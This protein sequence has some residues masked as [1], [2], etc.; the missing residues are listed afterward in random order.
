[1]AR[2][3]LE[4]SL[5][6]PEGKLSA[7]QLARLQT[8]DND[9]ERA[10]AK[11]RM[12]SSTPETAKPKPKKRA[13]SKP[14]KPAGSTRPPKRPSSVRSAA[15]PE[16][17]VRKLNNV[18]GGRGDGLSEMARRAIDRAPKPK[19]VSAGAS[20]PPTQPGTP[21]SSGG[22]SVSRTSGSSSSPRTSP[23]RPSQP[24]RDRGPQPPKERGTTDT[25]N[26]RNQK[27]KGVSF[28]DWQD[29]NAAERRS[30]GLPTSVAAWRT[31]V[32]N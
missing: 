25:S 28:S 5:G 16:V 29:M 11:K 21:K 3:Q 12:L 8:M 31:A 30:K 20:N 9:R 10:K 27:V 15:A 24:S 1:M 7:S 19:A 14:S 26:Y 18:R 4:K 17:T 32:M 13:A 2:T 6:V 22:V 23:A